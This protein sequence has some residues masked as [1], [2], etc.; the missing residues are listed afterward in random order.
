MLSLTTGGFSWDHI[1]EFKNQYFK[2]E[3][4]LTLS[5]SKARVTT[6]E[7]LAERV[8]LQTKFLQLH[9]QIKGHV[10][11]LKID[12]SNAMVSSLD[13]AQHTDRQL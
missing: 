7:L 8:N 1:K 9:E 10:H 11:K 3:D 12:Y 4:Y 2:K 5:N 6:P 13:P